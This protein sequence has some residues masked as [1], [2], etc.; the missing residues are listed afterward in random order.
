[1]NP[2]SHMAKGLMWLL[3]A[4]SVLISCIKE[5]PDSREPH[6]PDDPSHNDFLPSLVIAAKEYEI[7]ASGGSFT[8][9][10]SSNVDVAV[11][12]PK[13]APWIS[14]E[15]SGGDGSFVFSVEPNEAAD[16]RSARIRFFSYEYSL[17]ETVSV[18]QSQKDA[19]VVDTQEVEVPEAGGTFQL[20]IESNT[21][22]SVSVSSSW[23][24][25]VTTKAL[26]EYDHSFMAEPLP[27]LEFSR[28]AVIVFT[29]ADGTIE[30]TVNVIQN[31]QSEIIAFAD[32][33]V[34]KVCVKHWDRN[35]DGELSAREAAAVQKLDHI[36]MNNRK[37]VSFNELRYFTGLRESGR[38][39]GCT[40][41]ESITLPDGIESISYMAFTSCSS[42]KSII[43]P[44]DVTLLDSFAFL[45]CTGLTDIEFF[46][47]EPPELGLDALDRTSFSCIYV[48]EAYVQNYKQNLAWFKYSH[49]ITTR[50]HKPTDYYYRS[51]DYSQDG[52]AVLLQKAT[53]GRGINIIFVGDGYTDRDVGSGGPLE[54]TAREFME[55]FF[56]LEPYRSFRNRFN[57]WLVK[58]VS[59]TQEFYTADSRRT[60]SKD[61]ADGGIEIDISRIFGYGGKVSN[62]YG[63]PV[64]M[65]LFFNA[66]VDMGR[67][68]C[69]R[70]VTSGECIAVIFEPLGTKPKV[71]NHELGGHGFAGL[72]DEYEEYAGYPSDPKSI[73][74]LFSRYGSYANIDWRSDP[75]T[76]RWAHLIAD[77]LYSGEGLGVF[78]GALKYSDG[79]YRPTE[80]SVMRNS[81]DRDVVFNAPSREQIY[82][83][84][85]RYSEGPGWSYKYQEFVKADEPGRQQAAEAY[86]K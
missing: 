27:A 37:V 10:V 1:M 21:A 19:I 54:R 47:P 39:S 35:S 48:Q 32:K 13:D 31:E 81:G 66:P 53:A 24:K 57:V 34:K 43:I 18:V 28:Q 52:K 7:D 55:Q 16:S 83:F 11:D 85:M 68:Y 8:V 14:A 65:C 20:T 67:S 62:P 6:G 42:L 44:A 58:V 75:K 74:E 26:S 77:S 63:I 17:S 71:I 82:K 84:I 60:L 5:D 2:W 64:K 86:Q 36:F 78:R 46:S 45:D 23:L 22:Y 30:K 56:L 69:E 79:Y 73:D 9:E 38:F 72:G 4:A 70:Y 25:E 76:V 15:S 61:K 33:E 80:N 50:G 29:S 41:L 12:M 49:I 40:A 51:S 59:E 3:L